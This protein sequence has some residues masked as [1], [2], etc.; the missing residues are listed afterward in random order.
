[1]SEKKTVKTYEHKLYTNK[2]MKLKVG[3]RV[4]RAEFANG[5]KRAQD[6][7]EG[8]VFSTYDTEIQTAIENHPEFNSGLIKIKSS[9][10]IS[11]EQ[12][13]NFVESQTTEANTAD[14]VQDQNSKSYPGVMEFNEVQRILKENFDAQHQEVASKSKAQ[15]FAKAKEV[16]FPDFEF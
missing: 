3:D 5:I 13:E 6:H 12:V 10:E 8:G 1:M 7:L 14:Q 15:E 11:G 16:T 2:S 9:V 4:I